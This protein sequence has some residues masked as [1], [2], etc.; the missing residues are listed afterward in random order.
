MQDQ[1][2]SSGADDE[3]SVGNILR[4]VMEPA[5]NLRER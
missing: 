1:I 5:E 4:G 3:R 2:S